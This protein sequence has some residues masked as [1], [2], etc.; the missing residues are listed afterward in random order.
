MAAWLGSQALINEAHFRVQSTKVNNSAPRS[1]SGEPGPG[2]GPERRHLGAA[3]LLQG[4]DP[5]SE[6]PGAEVEELPAE[7]QLEK[8]PDLD[9]LCVALTL[10]SV[11]LAQSHRPCGWRGSECKQEKLRAS[12]VW[13]TSGG[14]CAGSMRPSCRR[15]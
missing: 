1:Q 8:Q 13:A 3:A 9:G 12:Q 14:G 7:Q 15:R 6:D 5:R 11:M 4:A 10:E 2:P